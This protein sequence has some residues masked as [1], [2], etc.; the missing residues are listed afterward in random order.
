[1]AIQQ[2]K[3]FFLLF[4]LCLSMV[5]VS[6]GQSKLPGLD[7]IQNK[8]GKVE[9]PFD[10]IAGYILLKV[11]VQGILPLVFI[12][13]TGA[14]HTIFFEKQITDLLGFTY[15]NM[16][17]LRGSDVN[18]SVNALISRQISLEIENTPTVKRD[19]VVLE[20]NFLNLKQM[21]GTQIDGII[22]GSYFRNLIVEINYRK[23]KLILWHPDKF[24]KKLKGYT[25]SDI[26]IINNKPYMV[27]QTAKPNSEEQEIKLL[28]DT[29]AALTYLINTSP[30]KIITPP[31][32]AAP[33]NL[34]KGIGGFISGYKGKMKSLQI[35]EYTFNNILTHFQEIDDAIDPD[36]YN[37][38]DGLVGNLLLR[39]FNIVINYLEKEMY[40][41]PIRGLKKE[42]KY[43]LAGMELLAFGP[44]LRNFIVFEVVPGS[45]A[46][47][48]GIQKGDVIKKVGIYSA[49]KYTLFNLDNKL[50]RR[51][52]NKIK[53]VLLRDD[54]LIQKKIVLR[55]F[56]SN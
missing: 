51:A 10:F 18:T 5:Q 11:E 16:V 28:I 40:L 8:K 34:G 55:D 7:L 43:N 35:N 41:K 25:K 4:L 19:I 42:F 54:K 31:K 14:E 26:E 52:G 33:G 45:P 15:D 36:F 48:V 49:H 30:N 37:N 47:E 27:C 6:S 22:G 56:L 17:N 29:G 32:N 9:I 3:R 50:S 46:E 23:K 12:F 20:D 1:M 44:K 21:T 2:I 13:D 38:R 39:R 53:V 24:T